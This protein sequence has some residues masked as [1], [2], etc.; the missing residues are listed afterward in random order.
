MW[1]SPSPSLTSQG[2]G[3]DLTQVATI[4]IDSISTFG[5]VERIGA[6]QVVPE[7]ASLAALGFG[8]LALL[9]RRRRS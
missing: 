4:Y 5:N 1:P 2:G 6:V 3:F 7:P 9:K 8:A